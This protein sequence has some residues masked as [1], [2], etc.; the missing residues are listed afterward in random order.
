MAMFVTAPLTT[1]TASMQLSVKPHKH[2]YEEPLSKSTQIT[3]TNTALTLQEKRKM[4]L[5]LR[6][7]G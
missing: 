5:M 1:I 2:I 6:S 7:G 3:R 4:E